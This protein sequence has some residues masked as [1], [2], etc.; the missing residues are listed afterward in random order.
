MFCLF[1]K[2]IFFFQYAKPGRKVAQTFAST[3]YRIAPF[4]NRVGYDDKAVFAVDL[5][6]KRLFVRKHV[7]P[8]RVLDQE[9][10]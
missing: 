3:F 10:Q 4:L 1:D 6:A 5:D 7:V 9:L 2:D 8:D